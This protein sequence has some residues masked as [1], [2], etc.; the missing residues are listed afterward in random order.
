MPRLP[1]RHYLMARVTIVGAGII[2]LCSA[3]FARKKGFEVWVLDRDPEGTDSCSTGNAGMIVPSH[4]VPLA[5]PGVV[6]M[7]VKMMFKPKAPFAFKIPPTIEQIL[8]SW[9]FM[10]KSDKEHVDK[11][12]TILR[13]LNLE[14]ESCTK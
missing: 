5:A 13:D 4:F 11:C 1:R 9:M 2:G 10:G 7:G 14:V 8:W 3:Y 6:K 12:E